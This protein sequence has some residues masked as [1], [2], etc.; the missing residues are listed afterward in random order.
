MD[1]TIISVA[2]DY[3][4]ALRRINVS[5]PIELI[6]ELLDLM[7]QL[8]DAGKVRQSDNKQH[9]VLDFIGNVVEKTGPR[10]VWKRLLEAHPDT[11]IFCNSVKLPRID[12]KKGNLDSPVTNELGL[13]TIAY[14]LP[15]KLG[16]RIRKASA[17]LEIDKILADNDLVPHADMELKLYGNNKSTLYMWGEFLTYHHT[18]GSRHKVVDIRANS[19]ATTKYELLIGG[20]SDESIAW[21]EVNFKPAKQPPST[22]VSQFK[23]VWEAPKYAPIWVVN[24]NMEVRN[25]FSGSEQGAREA[26][27]NAKKLKNTWLVVIECPELNFRE[28]WKKAQNSTLKQGTKS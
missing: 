3:Q 19:E 21:I 26:V 1:T 18:F 22:P 12:G 2:A 8:K 15:G 16:D 11:V 27:E 5:L 13:M 9:S 28:E 23:R 24:R 25:F 17:Q 14:L 7:G 6:E 4:V 20:C 10:V